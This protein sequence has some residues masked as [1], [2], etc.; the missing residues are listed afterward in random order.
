MGY[1]FTLQGWLYL[2]WLMLSTLTH[3]G[4]LPARESLKPKIFDKM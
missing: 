2:P 1:S 3:G 4:V